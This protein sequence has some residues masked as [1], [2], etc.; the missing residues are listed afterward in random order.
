MQNYIKSTNFLQI[1]Q[2]SSSYTEPHVVM[3]YISL[4]TSYT[5]YEKHS[6]PTWLHHNNHT[7]QGVRW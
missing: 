3:K 2:L 6:G 5:N 1:W 4:Y 7:A